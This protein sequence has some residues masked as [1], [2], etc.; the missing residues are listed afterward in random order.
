MFG[1]FKSYEAEIRELSEY[2]TDDWH[3]KSIYAN[4]FLDSYKKEVGGSLALCR[5]RL[6]AAQNSSDPGQSLA[7]LSMLGQEFPM[8][9][10]NAA[11]SGY[12]S[13]LRRGR[14]VGTVVEKSIWAILSNR[15]DIVDQ[16]DPAFGRY[17]DKTFEEKFPGLFDEVFES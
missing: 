2:L 12:M 17:I 13:D 16:M 1:F 10:V 14:Y 4:A 15:S 7:G 9:L 5:K 11:Y 3:M 6:S 8:A